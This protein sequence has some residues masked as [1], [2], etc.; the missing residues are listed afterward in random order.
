MSAQEKAV[1]VAME[2]AKQIIAISTAILVLTG[3]FFEKL[4][5]MTSF[6]RT[7]LAAAWGV[8][9][10]AVILGLVAFMISAG[11]LAGKTGLDVVKR[12]DL[13]VV[14][15]L[16]VVVFFIAVLLM[17]IFAFSRLSPTVKLPTDI[18]P[19]QKTTSR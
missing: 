4:D 6:Q 8:F 5:G 7:L 10:L 15:A 13:R 12:P 19:A 3:V 14:T 2:I 18:K 9:F 17:L 11:A 1:D 16:Q